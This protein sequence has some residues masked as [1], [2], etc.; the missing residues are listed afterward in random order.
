MSIQAEETQDGVIFHLHLSDN[1]P[2][3]EAMLGDTPVIWKDVIV[4]GTYPMSPAPGGAVEEP[5]TVI[6]EGESDAKK[7]II[8]MSDLEFSHADGAFKYVTIPTTH[9]DGVLDNTGYVPRPDGVRVI[10]KEIEGKQRHVF[11]A[12]LGFTEPDVKGK[13]QR[14][15]IPDVSGGIFFNWKN[16]AKA[17]VY[18][19]AMKHVALTP[20]PFMGNLDG[21]A[22]VYAADEEIENDKLEIKS[23]TFDA[24]DGSSGDSST[25]TTGEIVWN[26]TEG[27]GWI[28]DQ[29]DAA[30]N[31]E[32]DP[33]QP[34]AERP[35]YYV[36]DVSTGN[37]ALV[38]ESFRGKR[39]RFVVPFS[40][41]NDGQIEISPPTR[42]V[43]AKEAMI[44]AS[45]DNKDNK[46]SFADLST[47][48]VRE[49]LSIALSEELGPHATGYRVEE[50][51]LDSRARIVSTVDGAQY[52]APFVVR[53]GGKVFFAEPSSQWER[54][55]PAPSAGATEPPA[56]APSS[57][58]VV[59]FDDNTPEGRVKAARERRKQL[60]A[61]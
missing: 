60:L 56:P 30:L 42:W 24:G 26:E 40:K 37:N 51:S 6:R 18:R 11:Q 46:L 41:N 48:K 12:A 10:E 36:Q 52:V 61:S 39:T 43:E 25:S 45:D 28:R 57:E 49:Q 50:V 33:N 21:F 8:S 53:P 15:T 38:N 3:E 5:L 17:K 4:E 27:M 55:A 31:P 13:V 54:L 23:F 47:E 9:R 1:T 59:N 32:P 19:C 22:P 20:N 2:G 7:R 14:G 35:F 58:K 34:P 29:V 44:A 16:K